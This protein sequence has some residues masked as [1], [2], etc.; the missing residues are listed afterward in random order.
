LQQLFYA[1]VQC[2]TVLQEKPAMNDAD[3]V[4]RRPQPEI[5]EVPELS[6]LL[7][8]GE[9]MLER[10]QG[11]HEACVQVLRSLLGEVTDLTNWNEWEAREPR[12]DENV[13]AKGGF[14][15]IDSPK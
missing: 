9:D 3:Q 1:L 11:V 10:A 12:P 15:E 2:R 5:R 7:C 13:S 6:R 4:N 8:E 14:P